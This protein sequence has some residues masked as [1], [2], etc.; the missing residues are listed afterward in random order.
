MQESV[1]EDFFSSYFHKESLN[2]QKKEE[3]EKVQLDV[4]LREVRV[5]ASTPASM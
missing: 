2:I 5:V 3:L 1:W 4:L